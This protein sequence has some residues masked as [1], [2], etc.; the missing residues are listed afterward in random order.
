MLATVIGLGTLFLGATGAFT[1]LK[2]ALNV[3]WDVKDEGGGVLSL[4]RGRLWAFA[5]V[6][7]V[8]FLLLVSLLAIGRPAGGGRFLPGWAFPR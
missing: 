7:V 1:E 6:L 5:M 2:S 3:V 4:L 8:G